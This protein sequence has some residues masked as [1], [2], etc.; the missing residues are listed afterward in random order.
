MKRKP[1]IP[2]PEPENWSLESAH[3]NPEK[4]KQKTVNVFEQIK[5]DRTMSFGGL[6]PE[7]SAF[8]DEMCRKVGALNH[9]NLPALPSRD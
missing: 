6:V 2:R 7:R 5:Y 3:V 4:P 8:L 1:T 9:E